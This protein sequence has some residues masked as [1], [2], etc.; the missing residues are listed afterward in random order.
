ME[1]KLVQVTEVGDFINK[2]EI[3]NSSDDNLDKTEVLEEN[4]LNNSDDETSVRV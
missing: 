3:L 2:G 1:V 4:V